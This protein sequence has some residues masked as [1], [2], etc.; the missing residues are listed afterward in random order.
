MQMSV[1]MWAPWLLV[2]LRGRIVG[3]APLLLPCESLSIGIRF[4]VW[5]SGVTTDD[6]SSL[7]KVTCFKLWSF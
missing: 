6:P 4:A 7:S 2:D 3:I 1:Y 5:S